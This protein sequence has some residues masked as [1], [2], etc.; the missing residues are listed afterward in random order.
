[1]RVKANVG[2][3]GSVNGLRGSV[4]MMVVVVQMRHIRVVQSFY[5][6]KVLLDNVGDRDSV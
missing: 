5:C 6:N 3:E 1:M 4:V 2:G